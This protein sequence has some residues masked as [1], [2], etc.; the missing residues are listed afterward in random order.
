[1]LCMMC[2][3][4]WNVV[5]P[6]LYVT[7]SDLHLRKCSNLNPAFHPWRK[8]MTSKWIWRPWQSEGTGVFWILSSS[9]FFRTALFLKLLLIIPSC[10]KKKKK[11]SPPPPP[12]IIFHIYSHQNTSWER[13]PEPL[14]WAHGS[15]AWRSERSLFDISIL[16]DPPPPPFFLKNNMNQ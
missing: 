4:L 2:N 11:K 8:M 6:Q 10:F 15:P 16:M 13:K 7:Q 12:P 1:M 5:T 14:P 9:A 3:V